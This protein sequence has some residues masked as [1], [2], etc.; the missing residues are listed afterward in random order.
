[1]NSRLRAPFCPA[2]DCFSEHGF[3]GVAGAPQAASANFPE[4]FSGKFLNL[5]T[6]PKAEII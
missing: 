3:P 6:L 2:L 4:K 1:V 5:L